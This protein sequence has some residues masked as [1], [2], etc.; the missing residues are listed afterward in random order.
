MS[1]RRV[2]GARPPLFVLGQAEPEQ[3]SLRIEG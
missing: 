1:R 3:L 2:R